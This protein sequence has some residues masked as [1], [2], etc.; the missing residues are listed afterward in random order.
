M[1]QVGDYAE[2]AGRIHDWAQQTDHAQPG[3]PVKAAAI[4]EIAQAESPPLRLRL[5]ADS[6]TRVEAELAVVTEELAD[7]RRLVLS[8]GHEVTS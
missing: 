8:T 4:V 6:V 5:A 2:S 3:D 1:K 7:R